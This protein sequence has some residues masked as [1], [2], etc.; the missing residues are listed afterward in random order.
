MIQFLFPNHL[1]Q[2]IH[3]FLPSFCK[4][5]SVIANYIIGGAM[6]S[7]IYY[8]SFYVQRRLIISIHFLIT[9]YNISE[10]WLYEIVTNFISF[11]LYIISKRSPSITQLP[12][13]YHTK[14]C[15]F[16]GS[17]IF[18]QISYSGLSFHENVYLVGLNPISYIIF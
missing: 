13:E 6:I 1:F 14:A 5:C 12:M 8:M 15:S 4:Y 3:Q 16:E 17:R 2:I 10:C 11:S 9:V 18:Q 7:I